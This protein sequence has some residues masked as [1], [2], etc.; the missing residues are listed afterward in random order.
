MK[1][2]LFAAFSL[3]ILLVGNATMAPLA[4]A[5][6]PTPISSCPY[7]ITTPGNYVVTTNLTSSGS[8]ITITVDDVSIDL[9]GHSITGT[10]GGF[11]IGGNNNEVITNGTVTKF[12]IGLNLPGYFNTVSGM[13]VEQNS[14]SPGQGILLGYGST[15]TDTSVSGNTAM[16]IQG[17]TIMVNNSSVDN[18]DDLGISGNNLVV[19]N[20][21]VNNNG[22]GG[23]D[24]F[25]NEN[26]T[27]YVAGVSAKNNGGAGIS[28]HGYGS[29][30]VIDSNVTGN[31]AG[32]AI[33]GGT[34]MGNTVQ[35]N[36]DYGIS[37]TCPAN[38]TGNT[39]KNNTG[40]N[41]VTSD[42]TCVLWNN[43]TSP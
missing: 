11:G 14:G 15:V 30:Q 18:N 42:N 23:I 41:I 12:A 9:Q 28:I 13:T 17:N 20:S 22:I 36:A 34:V 29:G 7:S 6:S 25:T 3:L 24:I 40:G 21:E 10:A 26:E 27:G 33:V 16:G 8:C 19:I 39:V 5:A 4:W 43:K 35:N 2:T 37:L 31:P 38:A 32:I 1:R